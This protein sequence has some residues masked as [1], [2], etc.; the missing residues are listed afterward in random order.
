L[1][2][3]VALSVT[4]YHNLMNWYELAFAKKK[5]S[6]IANKEHMTFRKLSVMAQAL[7]EEEKEI[8]KDEEEDGKC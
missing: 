6:D 5:P 7:V 2:Q 3:E 4:D 8:A 1:S